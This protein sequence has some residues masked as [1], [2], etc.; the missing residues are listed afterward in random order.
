MPVIIRK[1]WVCIINIKTDPNCWYTKPFH[2]KLGPSLSWFCFET[3]HCHVLLNG[4]LST[5]SSSTHPKH[6]FFPFSKQ[7]P[8]PGLLHCTRETEAQDLQSAECCSCG[9]LEA[10]LPSPISP[11]SDTGWLS[12][13]QGLQAVHTAMGSPRC[14]VYRVVLLT[15][16]KASR[17]GL[18]TKTPSCPLSGELFPAPLSLPKP[19]LTNQLLLQK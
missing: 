15:C 14:K 13:P 8:V 7:E 2:W 17:P 1:K 10:M 12:L 9:S 4:K 19:V 5:S 6:D 18:I 3:S 11:Q 16:S